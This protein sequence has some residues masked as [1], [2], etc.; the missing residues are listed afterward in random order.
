[1]TNNF[2]CV[3]LQALTIKIISIIMS[4]VKAF[5]CQT[6]SSG[7]DNERCNG[8]KKSKTISGDLEDAANV[9]NWTAETGM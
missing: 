2:V 4:E 1:M 6:G 7:K 8:V 9:R 3:V 5:D